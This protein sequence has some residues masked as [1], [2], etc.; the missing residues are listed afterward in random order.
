M[1]FHTRQIDF[2]FNHF[3]MDNIEVP[4]RIQILE[5]IL[6]SLNPLLPNAN[7]SYSFIKIS[8]K[9]KRID[10]ENFFL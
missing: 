8:F 9:K 1:N 6:R 5:S 2:I 7:Y 10:Q 3:N 4:S